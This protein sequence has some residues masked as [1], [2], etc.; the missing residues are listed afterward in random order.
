[1][2]KKHFEWAAAYVRAGKTPAG[3]PLSYTEAQAVRDGFYY[4]FNQFGPNFDGGRFLAAC[5]APRE[6]D[7]R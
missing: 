5:D 4:L 1:V 6:E 7:D 3:L 2:S